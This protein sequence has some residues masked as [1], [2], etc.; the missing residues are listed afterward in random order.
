MILA[1]HREAIEYDL[2]MAGKSLDDL[3]TLALSW[4]DLRTLIRRW[5]RTAGTALSEA[6]QG[7]TMWSIEA[8]L[9]AE[10]VDTL[11]SGNWQ[12]MQKKSAP[13]P[14]PIPRPWEKTKATRLGSEPIPISQF[15]DWWDSM[16]RK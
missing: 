6:V 8:Q 7:Y 4:R 2:L 12:R 1:K 14:K 15:D 10:A 11:R 5:Q 13:K 3:G 16:S 9:L